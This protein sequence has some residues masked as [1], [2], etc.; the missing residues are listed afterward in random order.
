MEAFVKVVLWLI[1]LVV[2]VLFNGYAL[3]ILWRWF[4]VPTFGLVQLSIPAAIGFSLTVSYLT[5]RSSELKSDDDDIAAAFI[6]AL[7]LP[8]LVLAFGYIVQLWMPS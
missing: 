5:T 8:T 3:T 7:L 2:S 4:V 1:A 6:R